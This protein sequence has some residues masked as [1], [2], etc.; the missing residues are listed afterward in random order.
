MAVENPPGGGNAGAGG[1]GGGGG[2]SGGGDGKGTVSYD[3]FQKLLDEKKAADRKLA[4]IST[5]L[6]EIQTRQ[7]A[8]EEQ[9]LA[10][11]Q[12][13]KELAEKREKELNEER[14]KTATLTA[15]QAKREK[16]DAFVQA[17]G[18]Q[19]EPRWSS[20]ID[21]QLDKISTDSSGRPDETSLKAAVEEFRKAW[22]E[23]F[24]KPGDPPGIPNDGKGGAP[25][26]K[27]TYDDWLKLPL[28]EQRTRIGDVDQNTLPG[29]KK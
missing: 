21:T 29:K 8:K 22:P 2:G 16:R 15:Q 3:S 12:K 9:D 14:A 7:K 13:F 18:V 27:L 17:M 26:G 4:E 28:K 25:T 24:K 6:N 20:L 10:D 19:A 11:S 5:Q 23:A 1:E